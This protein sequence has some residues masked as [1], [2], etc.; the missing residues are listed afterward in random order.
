MNAMHKRCVQE[1]AEEQRSC[2]NASADEP[3]RLFCHGLPG[4]GKTQVMHWLADVKACARQ[5][6]K[7]P[8]S[9]IDCQLIIDE[10]RLFK[11]AAEIEDNRADFY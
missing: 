1:A 5:G 11:S 8:T 3:K 4:S 2:V 7:A 10:M 9:F 6:I